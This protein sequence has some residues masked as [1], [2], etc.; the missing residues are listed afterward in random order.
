MPKPTV[1]VCVGLAAPI[2]PKDFGALFIFVFNAKARPRHHFR[3][4]AAAGYAAQ[5]LG[6]GL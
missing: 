5:A 3:A 6:R 4:G 2:K 1:S